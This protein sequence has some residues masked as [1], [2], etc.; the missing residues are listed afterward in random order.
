MGGGGRADWAPVQLGP[1]EPLPHRGGLDG[2]ALRRREGLRVEPRDRVLL[3]R[4]EP[5]FLFPKPRWARPEVH[6]FSGERVAACDVRADPAPLAALIAS[7]KGRCRR[8]HQFHVP[9]HSARPQDMTTMTTVNGE[10]SER[11]LNDFL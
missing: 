7:A 6:D 1:R 11:I 10:G 4:C 5:R 3:F 8:A 2:L 9:P